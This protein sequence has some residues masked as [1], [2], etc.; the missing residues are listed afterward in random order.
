M[1]RGERMSEPWMGDSAEREWA[2]VMLHFAAEKAAKLSKAG[3]ERFD[4]DWLL[5]YDN[6]PLPAVEEELAASFLV[7]KLAVEPKL[8]FSA[9]FVE[10]NKH[11]WH[12][13]DGKVEGTPINDIWKDS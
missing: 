10:G 7:G 9:I 13:E 12:F 11:F 1:A 2:D 4:R 5:I 3:F 8:P 6:W